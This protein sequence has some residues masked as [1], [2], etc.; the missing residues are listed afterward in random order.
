MTNTA[1]PL[2]GLANI[3]LALTPLIAVV[4]AIATGALVAV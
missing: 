3:V 1:F 4:M 2:A